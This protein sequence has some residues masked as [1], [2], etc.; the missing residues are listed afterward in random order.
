MHVPPLDVSNEPTEPEALLSEPP[1]AKAWL[2]MVGAS[3]APLLRSGDLLRIERCEED[4]LAVGDVGLVQNEL[5]VF[6]AHL[7]RGVRPLETCSMRGRADEGRLV[8]VGRVVAFKR[9]ARSIPLPIQSRRVVWGAFL[10]GLWLS[11]TAVTAPLRST[12]RKLRESELNRVVRRWRLNPID[13][14][15]LTFADCNVVTVFAADHLA[16]PG[17]FLR[18]QLKQRWTT[19][20]GAAG[21]FDKRGKLCGFAYLDSFREE[22]LDLDDWW[23]RCLFVIPEAREMDVGSRVVACLCEL[24]ARQGAEMVRA[25]IPGDNIASQ[26]LFK[27]QGFQESSP[28]WVE[29]VTSEWKRNGVDDRWVAVERRVAS[30]P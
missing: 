14:R 27:S 11:R 30:R 12:V 7:V 17:A 22:G 4:G 24:A 29:R 28:E 6:L 1:G 3:M 18:K 16:V 5:G 10:A 2:P 20:G 26:R 21:A 9:G 13:V 15:P 8:A 19:Q 23:V 25:D